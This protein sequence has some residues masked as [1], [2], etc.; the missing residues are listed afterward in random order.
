MKATRSADMAVLLFWG[1]PSLDRPGAAQSSAALRGNEELTTLQP[2]VPVLVRVLRLGAI[3]AC[4][5]REE[6]RAIDRQR[7]PI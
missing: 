5:P 6:S 4:G 2:I 1:V 7:N 3:L